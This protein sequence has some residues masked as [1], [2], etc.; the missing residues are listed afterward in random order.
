[1]TAFM[2]DTIKKTI[3]QP[4]SQP[5]NLWQRLE[6]AKSIEEAASLWL[7]I[8]AARM[9]RVRCAVI[10]LGPVD[11]GPY[12]PKAVWPNAQEPIELLLREAAEAVQKRRTKS[13]V[14]TSEEGKRQAVA[15]PLMLHNQLHGVI[16]LEFEAEFSPNLADVEV[17]LL[18]G[19]GWFEAAKA[20]QE[21]YQNKALERSRAIMTGAL[22]K[23]ADQT[24]FLPAS[25]AFVSYLASS[26]GCERVSLGF[27]HDGSLKMVALS[28]SARF[29]TEM[30]KSQK[31]LAVM[32]EALTQ[33]RFIYL[34][35]EDVSASARVTQQHLVESQGQAIAVVPFLVEGEHKAVLVLEWHDEPDVSRQELLAYLADMSRPTASLLLEKQRN[36]R[37]IFVKM[38]ASFSNQ[39]KRL[40]GKGYYKRKMAAITILLIIM[41][42]TLLQKDLQIAADTVIEAQERR[43]IV[44]PYD[45]FIASVQARQGDRVVL[46]TE[47]GNLDV[48]KLRLQKLK[49]ESELSSH[50]RRKRE[51]QARGQRAEMTILD[52]K[53][54]QTETELA[55]VKELLDQAVLTAPFDAVILSGDIKDL[56]GGSVTRG[57]L[58]FELAPA[59]KYRVILEVNE[60]DVALITE[61]QQGRM[62]LTSMPERPLQFDVIRIEPVAQSSEGK[63]FFRVEAQFT[64]I[65]PQLLHE[66]IRPGMQGTGK[67]NIGAQPLWYVWGRDFLNWMQIQLFKWAPWS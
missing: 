10:A 44:A 50:E 43:A 51:A 66:Y 60:Q 32:Q 30:S 23:V 8:F 20:H 11:Q 49:W 9:G 35:D 55:L 15:V 57:Q 37:S 52:A 28:H 26:F 46:G 18:A 22:E 58:L 17:K 21:L 6:Q 39:M 7:P 31:I 38:A 16:A 47:L 14:L 36:G 12:A 41:A 42:A 56:L 2:T 29:G 40:V 13:F 1:M 65:D 61:Q 67:I 19:L 3:K 45:G 59:D 27:E 24:E 62:I 54:A 34:P 4:S 5:R 53:I 63:T 48:N 25:A 64:N 33:A